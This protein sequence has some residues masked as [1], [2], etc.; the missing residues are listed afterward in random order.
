MDADCADGLACFHRADQEASEV[1]GCLGG[2]LIAIFDFCYRHYPNYGPLVYVSDS[3]AAKLGACQGDCGKSIRF[4]VSLNL[5]SRS[6][7]DSPI[8]DRCRHRQ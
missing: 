8:F 7:P 5:N 4:H 2:S 3:P 1:P 6:K